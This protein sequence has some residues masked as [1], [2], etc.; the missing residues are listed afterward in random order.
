[1]FAPAKTPQ[2]VIK[3]LNTEVVK[4]LN[5][6]L[7]VERMAG[8]GVDPA[9]STPAELTAYVKFEKEKWA[10]VIKQSGITAN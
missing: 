5:S 1:M 2:H 3:T 4:L 10:K 6:P 8:N 7:V 9:S